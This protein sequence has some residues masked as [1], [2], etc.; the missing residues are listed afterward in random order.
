M[1]TATAQT[2]DYL[3]PSADR[4]QTMSCQVPTEHSK[5]RGEEANLIIESFVF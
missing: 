3:F 4:G 1:F 5:A 2:D